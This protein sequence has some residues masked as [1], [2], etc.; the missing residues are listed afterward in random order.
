VGKEELISDLRGEK[1]NAAFVARCLDTLRDEDLLDPGFAML[2]PQ[3]FDGFEARYVLWLAGDHRQPENLNRRL[4]EL[5][6][7]NYHYKNCRYLAQLQPAKLSVIAEDTPRAF[8]IYQN[9]MTETGIRPG[10]IKFSPLS[11]LGDWTHTHDET[12][13]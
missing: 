1:L 8:A 10:E 2:A 5:L 11:R 3:E 7:E 4:E 9:R 13:S 6:C 12:P